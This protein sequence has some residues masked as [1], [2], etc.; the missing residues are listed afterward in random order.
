MELNVGDVT[1]KVDLDVGDVVEKVELVDL[2]AGDEAEKRVLNIGDAVEKVDLDERDESRSDSGL[3]IRS[4]SQ[5]LFFSLESFSC[6]IFKFTLF[7]FSLLA[8]FKMP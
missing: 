2:D 7:A 5:S 6:G 1:E 3:N 4:W 8:T